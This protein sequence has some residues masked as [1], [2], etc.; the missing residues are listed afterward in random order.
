MGQNDQLSG[1]GRAGSETTDDYALDKPYDLYGQPSPEQMSQID[2]MLL[3]LF[4]GA[5]A[6][7]ANI[8]TVRNSIAPAIA[9]AIAGIP[10]AVSDSTLRQ[11]ASYVVTDT[12][13]GN[14]GWGA[15][16]TTGALTDSNTEADATYMLI[17]TSGAGLSSRRF[18]QEDVTR[19]SFVPIHFEA[20]VRT[21]G[22]A[23]QDEYRVWCGL[24]GST[25]PIQSDTLGLGI[26]YR[27]HHP[28][29]SAVD[30]G[31][32]ILVVNDGTTQVE[33]DTLV[34]VVG[35][36]SGS[37]Y[38]VLSMDIDAANVTWS[39]NKGGTLFT[40]LATIPSTF[41]TVTRLTAM[42]ALTEI[43]AGGKVLKFSYMK[44]ST[45]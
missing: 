29:G 3:L 21:Y 19:L 13:I 23:N 10:S 35:G 38:Y 39:I 32:W 37:T 26:S 40:G 15:P 17:I 12:T 4:R 16:I 14:T 33:T 42:L 44:L 20:R 30:S 6:N 28:A 24:Q 25:S 22:A 1:G 41:S 8:T 34:P 5:T 31:N 18:S 27:Y 9:S 45:K 36:L 2:E 11:Y 43:A 7:R